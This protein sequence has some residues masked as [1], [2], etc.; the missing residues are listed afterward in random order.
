[1][2]YKGGRAGEGSHIHS[3]DCRWKGGGEKGT[4]TRLQRCSVSIGDL[5]AAKPGTDEVGKEDVLAKRR[6]AVDERTA[7]PLVLLVHLGQ[8]LGLQGGEIQ[9][10]Q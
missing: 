3:P 6:I 5:Q 1:M 2:G 8:E 9:L 10:I 4:L 7:A